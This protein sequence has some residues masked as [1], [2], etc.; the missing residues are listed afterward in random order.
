MDLK[1]IGWAAWSGFT[2]LK[3]GIVSGFFWMRW[4]TFGFWRHGANSLLY[5]TS[6]ELFSEPLRVFI[7]GTPALLND[8]SD[9]KWRIRQMV[10]WWP[11][12]K[13]TTETEIMATPVNGRYDSLR[14]QMAYCTRWS[15]SELYDNNYTI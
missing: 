9:N 11:I 8:R 15:Y 6:K 2:W 10:T 4:W 1:K 13:P 3:I 5:K 12:R 14:I 7:S